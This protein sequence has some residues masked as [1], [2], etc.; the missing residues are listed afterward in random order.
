M[1]FY[2][3]Y[4]DANSYPNGIPRCVSVEK[5]DSIYI[6]DNTPRKVGDEYEKYNA[7]ITE[8]IR[9]EK[10]WWQFWKRKTI[11]GYVITFE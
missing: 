6:M 1:G 10:K 7:V 3:M 9:E 5:G 8:V 4:L 2:K 11:Y